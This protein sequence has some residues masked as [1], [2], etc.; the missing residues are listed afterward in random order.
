[1]LAHPRVSILATIAGMSVLFFA[2]DILTPLGSTGGTLYV[3]VVLVSAWLASTRDTWL[4]AAFC[5][6]LILAG[7]L[8][9]PGSLLQAALLNRGLAV[10]VV[11]ATAVLLNRLL[12]SGRSLEIA[13]ER[14]PHAVLLVDPEGV[15]RFANRAIREVFD[16]DPSSLVGGSVDDLVPPQTR[17]AHPS[18]RAEFHADPV[19]R[20]MGMGRDLHAVRRDGSQFPVEVGL[21]PVQID[22]RSYVLCAI[23]DITGRKQAEAEIEQ[24]NR[25]LEALVY[26]MSHDLKEP[27]R[28][29][30][31]FSRLVQERAADRLNEKESDFLARVIRAAGRL[32]ILIDDIL[33]LSRARRG[34]LAVESRDVV[35]IIGDALERLSD[36]IETTGA[37]VEVEPDLPRLPIDRTWGT[38]AVYNLVL[39]ALKFTRPGIP[40]EIEIGRAQGNG[41]V[42]RDRGPG[43]AAE[44]SERIFALFQRAHG[45]DVDGVGAG[46][47]IVRTVAERHG[48][49]AWVQARPGGGSEFFITFSEPGDAP[50]EGS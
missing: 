12:L 6:A 41:L 11:W 9:S 43:V 21:N 48:G 5:T 19:A 29:I 46:L 44:H 20:P 1:M 42:V 7:F 2:A 24:H 39:N 37:R 16:H 27:L 28:A 38:E 10:F 50:E 15:I 40:P 33:T 8:L 23:T 26:V 30:E 22:R 47:A 17:A 32:R 13:L 18:L 14:L 4:V 34:K 45:R 36:R 25:D 49:R 31:S 35:E 3:A